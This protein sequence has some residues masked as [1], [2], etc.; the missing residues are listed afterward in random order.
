M[1]LKLAQLLCKHRVHANSAAGAGPA[2]VSAIVRPYATQ[3]VPGVG[4]PSALQR[5]QERTLTSYTSTSCLENKR[6]VHHRQPALNAAWPRY[7]STLAATDASGS[8]ASEHDWSDAVTEAEEVT[9][10]AV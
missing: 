6:R 10:N 5:Q 8:A 4:G 1:S 9:L 3:S 7:R 2:I